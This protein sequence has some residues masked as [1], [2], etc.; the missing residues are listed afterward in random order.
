MKYKT[1]NISTKINIFEVISYKSFEKPQRRLKLIL[2]V[3][4]LLNIKNTLFY[5]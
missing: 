2:Y 5:V 4:P 3:L 1:I